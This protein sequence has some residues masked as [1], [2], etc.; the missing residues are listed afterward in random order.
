MSLEGKLENCWID[1]AGN[2]TRDYRATGLSIDR[3]GSI[4]EA[5]GIPTGMT[6]GRNGGIRGPYGVSTGLGI[7]KI[8]QITRYY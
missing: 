5:Y 7:N 6:V 4:N 1:R 8:G 3:V 2:V